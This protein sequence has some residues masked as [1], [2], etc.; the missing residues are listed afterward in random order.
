MNISQASSSAS[1]THSSLSSSGPSWRPHHSDIIYRDDI[2]TNSD[3]FIYSFSLQEAD[4]SRV[5]LLLSP[6]WLPRVADSRHGKRSSQGELNF[7]NIFENN[8]FKFNQDSAHTFHSVSPK[9]TLQSEISD[10]SNQV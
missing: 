4:V 6:S 10:I 3:I 7:S 2:D 1:T 5:Q 9:N 8:I